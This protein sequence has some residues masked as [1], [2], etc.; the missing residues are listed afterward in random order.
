[1]AK[2][3]GIGIIG[4]GE[5]AAAHG[6]AYRALSDDC[7]IVAM[8]DTVEAMAR[9]RAHEFEVETIYTDYHDLLD[10]H[11][12]DVVAICTPHYLHAPMTIA[13]AHA[14][15]HVLVEKP[16]CMNVGEVQEM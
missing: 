12:V 15:K 4:C 8:S 11:R 14:G 9:H 1:M 13:A 2:K 5:I 6:R 3:F 16:M 10:D 7:E